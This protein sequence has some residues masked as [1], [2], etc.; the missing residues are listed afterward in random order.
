M[1]H[2]DEQMG[3]TAPS[4]APYL[5]IGRFR[6]TAISAISGKIWIRD[7]EGGESG[8]FDIEKLETAVKRFFREE[9]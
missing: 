7:M 2:K 6:L 5:D 4:R 8:A 1:G 9:F 3:D